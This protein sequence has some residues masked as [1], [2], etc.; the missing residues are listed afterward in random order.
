M[1]RLLKAASLTGLSLLGVVAP[2]SGLMAE[3]ARVDLMSFA[4][5]V[6]PVRINPTGEALRFQMAQAIAVIDGS[7]AG[8]VAMQKPASESDAIEVL[9]QLP[10]LTQFDRFAVP[11]ITETPSPSQTFFRTVEVRG[12]AQGPDGP[13]TLLARGELAVHGGPGEVTELDLVA[14]Q[15]EVGWVSLRLQGGINVEREKTFLEFS[16]LIGNG[17]QRVSPSS[18]RFSGVWSGRGVAMELRQAQVSVTGCYD[19]NAT[20]AGTVDGT[21]L[22]ALGADAAGIPSQFIL[23]VT[24]D[25]AMRGL[26]SSNGA[27]FKPYNGEASAAAPTCLP[28]ESA[29]LGCGSIVHGIGFNFDSAEIRPE[30]APII[31]ALFAGLSGDAAGSVQIIGHSSSE[32]EADYN[33]ALSR[34]R[35]ESVV[36]ALI[37][38]GLESSRL[39]AAGRGEAEPIASNDD[40]AGRSLNR[41]VEVTCSG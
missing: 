8:F 21:V 13:F 25:G 4:Q 30:S 40:E 19:T 12:S 36:Q 26:R 22:R 18:D 17:R 39:S 14:D 38:L 35:A 32:G 28:R 2:M 16:E 29:Q 27:P 37:T 31:E 34:R 15:P 41:R 1:R 24:E 20:L 9:Y 6:L 11:N 23:I 7:R 5:G 10:A 3:E 33:L